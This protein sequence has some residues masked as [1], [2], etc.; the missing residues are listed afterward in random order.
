MQRLIINRHTVDQGDSV[1]IT[2]ATLAAATT[3]SIVLLSLQDSVEVIGPVRSVE[4]INI[5]QD[6]AL[7]RARDVGQT[8]RSEWDDWCA[9]QGSTGYTVERI[10][11]KAE[12]ESLSS[13]KASMEF[14]VFRI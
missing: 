8:A 1:A 14:T 11:Q 12:E 9:L 7:Q 6:N 2:V 4:V 10:P 3:P 5:G 13:S